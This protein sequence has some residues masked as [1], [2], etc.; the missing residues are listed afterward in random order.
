MEKHH[1]LQQVKLNKIIYP[2]LIGLL[3]VAYMIYSDLNTHKLKIQFLDYP[4]LSSKAYTYEINSDNNIVDISLKDSSLLQQP[5]LKVKL[6]YWIDNSENTSFHA[7][8]IVL[9]CKLGEKI[10]GTNGL[11]NIE[12]PGKNHIRFVFNNTLQN[13]LKGLNINW[14]SIIF[15]VIAVSM[16]LIRDF[17]YTWR[18]RILTDKQLGWWQALR[19]ILLWEFTSALT[20]S[21]IGGS[22]VAIFLLSKEN[23]SLGKST[24]VVMATI[25][26]D[27]IYFL[28]FV[29][30]V[31]L[32]T[33]FDSLF[34]IQ[35]AISV[36]VGNY[37]EFFYF[38][39]IGYIAIFAFTAILSY[40]LFINPRGLKWMIIKIFRLKFLR[41]WLHAAAQTGDEIIISSKELRK[42]SAGFWIKS[43]LGTIFSWTARYWI[44][45]FLLLAFFTVGDH[46]LVFA[47]QL[48]MW[49]M[50][51]V[52]PT[53]GGSGFSEYVFATYLG[54]FIPDGLETALALIWRLITYYPY[55]LIGAILF[56]E[57]IKLKFGKK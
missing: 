4:S 35:S 9:N 24:A 12:I 21:A 7:D 15:L 10:A 50:M 28:V 49:I 14:H 48:V 25:F 44:V 54:Q 55:L 19:I 6:S 3:V 17:G 18:I 13:V 46:F 20:P 2:I 47:R 27:E 26:L 8:T 39:L 1:I 11:K 30:L 38:A 16:M 51:L 34:N 43:S 52:S 36:N 53:P 42:K 32:F 37:S 57:W 22:A 45:N 41:K 29:P 5:K 56:P 40:G 33:S 31:M 23:I